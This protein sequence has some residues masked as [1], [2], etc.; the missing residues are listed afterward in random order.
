M[1]KPTGCSSESIGIP[2]C[3]RFPKVCSHVPWEVQR[4]RAKGRL[5]RKQLGNK[6]LDADGGVD[7]RSLARTDHDAGVLGGLGRTARAA[8][9]ISCSRGLLFALAPAWTRA[10]RNRL[11]GVQLIK[12]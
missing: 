10:R 1:T 11:R 9:I 3:I 8:E 12:K 5:T 6:D 4:G 7:A 2:G